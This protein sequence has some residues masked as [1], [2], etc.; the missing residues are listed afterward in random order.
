MSDVGEIFL[1]LSGLLLGKLSPFMLL[2]QSTLQASVQANLLPQV[3]LLKF[4]GRNFDHA[5]K[6]GL[7][8]RMRRREKEKKGM[9]QEMVINNESMK[10]GESVSGPT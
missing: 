6:H 4:L 3:L 1:P 7:H 2:H 10:G 8:W 9:G 5:P